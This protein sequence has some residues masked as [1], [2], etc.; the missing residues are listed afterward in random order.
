M[1]RGNESYLVLGEISNNVRKNRD[2]ESCCGIFY[3]C[4]DDAGM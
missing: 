4:F 2:G 1:S 3:K